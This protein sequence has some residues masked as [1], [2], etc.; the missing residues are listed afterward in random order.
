[1]P[2]Q[3]PAPTPESEWEET[4]KIQD[5][6]EGYRE[7]VNWRH[8][9]NLLQALVPSVVPGGQG[10]YLVR[11]VGLEESPGFIGWRKVRE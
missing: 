7:A 6:G 3:V 1:M 8:Q 4:S 10:S 2:K 11:L 5:I 9:S